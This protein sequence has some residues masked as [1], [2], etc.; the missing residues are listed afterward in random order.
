MAIMKLQLTKILDLAEVR[1]KSQKILDSN[2]ILEVEKIDKT[3]LCPRWG[4]S[5]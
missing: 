4:H 3:A 2:I 5:Q 1:V